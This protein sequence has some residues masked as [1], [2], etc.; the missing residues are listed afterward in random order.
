[1]PLYYADP[2]SFGAVG[3]NAGFSPPF[4]SATVESYANGGAFSP[5]N[6]LSWSGQFLL[7]SWTLPL[8][9]GA[10]W[11]FAWKFQ[12]P[13]CSG[14][15]FET[16]GYLADP[17]GQPTA[18]FKLHLEG[19]NTL[20]LY[21]AGSP[22][23]LFFNTGGNAGF[24]AQ[25]NVW[26]YFQV[27]ITTGFASGPPY[28][29]TNLVNIYIDGGLICS[30]VTGTSNFL[31]GPSP[32]YV[33]SGGLLG[34]PGSFDNGSCAMNAAW[35]FQPNG[36]GN[37]GL[38]EVYVGGGTGGVLAYPGNLWTLVI[39]NPGSDYGP[40]P[41]VINVSSGDAEVGATLTLTPPVTGTGPVTG[42]YFDYQGDSYAAGGPNILLTA[43]PFGTPNG[44]GF[45]GH[46]TTTPLPHKRVSQMV[47]ENANL[48]INSNI[49]IS[50]MVVENAGRPTTSNL[51]IS[52][53]VIELPAAAIPPTPP[54]STGLPLW[55]E[56]DLLKSSGAS[57]WTDEDLW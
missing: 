49:R 22:D 37:A 19:D 48:P 27:E 23:T 10:T 12:G 43:T 46:A 7:T 11:W 41:P 28:F 36:S 8:V 1:M 31:V 52:Q 51:R 25:S 26:Y 39:D 18:T 38:T 40:L 33:S 17:V 47:V 13:I 4:G 20:S 2:I 50:Q 45:S 21:V 42:L 9:N 14:P 34:S 53:M 29:L 30:G 3:S 15:I 56:T 44:S 6:W 35:F 16:I 55:T 24:V 57:S 32:L 54:S 5:H